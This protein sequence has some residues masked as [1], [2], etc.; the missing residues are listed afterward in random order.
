LKGLNIRLL[1]T[2]QLRRHVREDR[3]ANLASCH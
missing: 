3:P 1:G 2:K